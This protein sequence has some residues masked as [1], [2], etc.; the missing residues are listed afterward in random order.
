MS[1][2]EDELN[3]LEH[4]SFSIVILSI[5]EAIMPTCKRVTFS[6][7]GWIPRTLST[8]CPSPLRRSCHSLKLTELVTEFRLSSVF[9]HVGPLW[10][11]LSH[12]LQTPAIE[13]VSL[14]CDAS[15]DSWRILQSMAIPGLEMLSITT[16]GHT[17]PLFPH[18]FNKLHPKLKFLSVLNLHSWQSPDTLQLPSIHLSLPALSHLAISSN[19][20]SFEIQDAIELSRL[21]VVSFMTLPVPENRGYCIVVESLTRALKSPISSQHFS[22]SLTV[23]FTFPRF[24]D[25]H[26]RFCEENPIYQCSCSPQ[27]HLVKNLRNIEVRADVLSEAFVVGSSFNIVAIFDPVYRVTSAL[28]SANSLRSST[29]AS[30]PI[31]LLLL[32]NCP[33]HPDF[34][35]TVKKFEKLPFHMAERHQ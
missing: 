18:S 1:F 17:L 3:I 13:V 25:D 30:S 16:R 4:P 34:A 35:Y 10:D 5:L 31:G 22:T 28:G 23:S 29:S 21:S 8:P 24:L 27:G 14:D 7:G 20:S 26:L 32:I 11:M 6:A 12:F 19:Y 33:H 2:L 9:S 15:E